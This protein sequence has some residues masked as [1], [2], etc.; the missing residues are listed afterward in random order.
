MQ[1]NQ[2]FINRATEVV[3]LVIPAFLKLA[4]SSQSNTEMRKALNCSEHDLTVDH[5]MDHWIQK[6]HDPALF[7]LNLDRFG[8][9]A[10]LEWF[11]LNPEDD[12]VTDFSKKMAMKL[13]G[14]S[15]FDIYSFETRVVY[16]FLLLSNNNSITEIVNHTLNSDSLK[17]AFENGA[18][19][20]YGNGINWSTYYAYLVQ[21]KIEER[22]LIIKLAISDK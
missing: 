15:D 2:D 7:Y 20:P 11:G 14:K 6:K 17:K 18:F 12:K 13:N 19:D 4:T 1:F 3:D 5:L 9:K 22:K 21:E 16:K 8:Q 10:L